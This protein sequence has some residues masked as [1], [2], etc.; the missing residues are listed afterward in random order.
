MKKWNVKKYD[1]L[2][3]KLLY[4]P[5]SNSPENTFRELHIKADESSTHFSVGISDGYEYT[6]VKYIKGIDPL[7]KHIRLILNE[8]NLSV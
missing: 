4:F 3:Q 1:S 5:L 7:K 8:E 2:F 6:S